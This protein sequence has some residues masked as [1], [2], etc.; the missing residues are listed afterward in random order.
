M[1][2]IVATEYVSVDGVFDEPGYWS[3]PFW[4]DESAQF[5][6]NELFASDALLLG[7]ITYVGFAAAWPTM[8]DEQG[9]ADRM[10]GMQKFVVSK[11]LTN[12][13]WTNTAV[14][15]DNFLD[16]IAKHKQQDGLDIL[17]AGSGQLVKT[18]LHENLIDEYRLMV[19]PIIL[20]AGKR[21]FREGVDWKVLK[22]SNVKTFASGVSVLSYEPAPAD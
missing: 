22:L 8:T 14:L 11:T 17:L 20:G 3:F 1:R 5:K 13:T 21:L 9:F 19:H 12:P 2:K 16:E 4:S 7:R 18:L 6:F 10:N 15:G